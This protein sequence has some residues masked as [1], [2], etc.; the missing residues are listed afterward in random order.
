MCFVSERSFYAIIV[1]ARIVMLCF[2]R[3]SVLCV[4]YGRYFIKDLIRSLVC[5]MICAK[6]GV[7]TTHGMS[8]MFSR[9]YW[10][11]HS[12]QASLCCLCHRCGSGIC[13]LLRFSSKETLYRM[14]GMT[15]IDVSV[16][17][18]CIYTHLHRDS[19]FPCCSDLP[20]HWFQMYCHHRLYHI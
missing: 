20:Q 18:F 3:H 15:R 5:D 7:E 16:H 9:S 17:C 13:G 4:W 1:V 2:S 12:G 8:C 11:I 19:H 10:K 14:E 6:W